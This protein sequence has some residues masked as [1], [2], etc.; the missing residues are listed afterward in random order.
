[1]SMLHE[2]IGVPESEYGAIRTLTPSLNH[3]L[4]RRRYQ[5]S[6]PA[7][8]DLSDRGRAPVNP[9]D[10]LQLSQSSSKHRPFYLLTKRGIDVVGA[11]AAI[12]LFSPLMLL[13]ALVIK[14]TDWGPI[15]YVHR[16]VGLHGS[17][18]N[19]IKFRS[20]V[21]DAESQK[22]QLQFHNAHDDPR[23]FKMPNDPRVTWIGRLLRRSSIDELPQ[24]FNVLIGHMSIV[25]PRPPVPSEVERYSLHDRRR[26]GVKPGL[27]CIWQVSGRSR[28]A[29]SEQ[30]QLDLEYI[31]KRSHWLDLVLI[32][33]T[34]PAV[35]SADGAY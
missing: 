3:R 28:L 23:T 22:V 31:E 24:L 9:A 12:L 33:R 1:M 19:C 6:R 17:E 14:L 30:L 5:H 13:T 32:L 26:L 4:R 25:G 20:M 35:F 29:F 10:E 27:T 7:S 18:F 21:V 16:R 2:D 34:F 11:L 15:F 8:R